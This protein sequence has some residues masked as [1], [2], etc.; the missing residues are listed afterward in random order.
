[1]NHFHAHIINEFLISTFET[2]CSWYWGIK[3]SFMSIHVIFSVDLEQAPWD[4]HWNPI[5]KV[6]H[7]NEFCVWEGNSCEYHISRPSM[8]MLSKRCHVY[9]CTREWLWKNKTR[10]HFHWR[11]QIV[12][13]T[14]LFIYLK[15]MSADT[16]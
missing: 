4:F 11:W 5:S 12:G 16:D 9:T 13:H 2:I 15:E 8:H 14:V 1:M 10:I 6:H 7:N 3:L